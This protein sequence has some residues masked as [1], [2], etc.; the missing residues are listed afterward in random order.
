MILYLMNYH[1]YNLKVF[2]QMR[3]PD[4]F[5]W[6]RF[7]FQGGGVELFSSGAESIKEYTTFGV[8]P[9]YIQWQLLH[10]GQKHAISN[11]SETYLCP[12]APHPSVFH[13]YKLAKL[14]SVYTSISFF[15]DLGKFEIFNIQILIFCKKKFQIDSLIIVRFRDFQI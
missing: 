1:W 14:E 9:L 2:N 12:K 11:I 7:N 10:Q 4:F 13:R 6:G 5:I 3:V 8:C 15:A